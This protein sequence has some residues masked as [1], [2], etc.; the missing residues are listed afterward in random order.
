MAPPCVNQ[1][2]KGGKGREGGADR[3]TVTGGGG[4]GWLSRYLRMY[5][6]SYVPTTQ[7]NLGNPPKPLPP[8]APRSTDAHPNTHTHI[9]TH[10]Q[11]GSGNEMMSVRGLRW[12]EGWISTRTNTSVSHPDSPSRK[13]ESCKQRR[14]GR[15]G[16]G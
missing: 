9:R 16:G 15:S 2:Q 14:S 10:G 8:K 13:S 5:S 6:Y 11:L 1:G 3:V 12:G 4:K 7:T